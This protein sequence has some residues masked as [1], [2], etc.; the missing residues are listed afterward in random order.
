MTAMNPAPTD[1]QPVLSPAAAF[2]KLLTGNQREQIAAQLPHGIEVDRFI[3]TA[4]TV[5]SM[6][7]ELL[8]C[9]MKSL[10]GSIMMAA[11]DGLLP[12]G[13]QALIQPYN[14]N[15]AGKNQP[16]KWEKQAQYLPMVRGLIDILYRTGN[17]AMVDGVAV[18]AKD[19]FEYERGDAPRIVHKP[20]MGAEDAGPVI[21]A[22][23]VITLTNGAIKREVMTGR[24]IAAVR[25]MAKSDTGWK[26]WEDQFAI[27]AVVKRAYKQLP[28]HQQLEQ[29]IQ[30]DNLQFDLEHD[31]T[32]EPLKIAAQPGQPARL[33]AIIN[34]AQPQPVQAAQPRTQSVLEPVFFGDDD[35][36]GEAPV[37]DR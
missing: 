27:K 32:P 34:R 12:D 10:L 24:D 9:T 17:V 25:A 14:C 35:T 13:K 20:Y 23:V 15:V 6:N 2:K 21:A 18:R 22:Y 33:Q 37:Y 19:I 7:P 8:T 3:R 1:N 36:F 28:T 16:P 4:L 5:V 11:K 30:H 31:S 29:V 26:K